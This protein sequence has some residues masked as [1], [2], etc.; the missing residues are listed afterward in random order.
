VAVKEIRKI[1]VNVAVENSVVYPS[2]KIKKWA[3][4]GRT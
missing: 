4:V 3:G 2:V 1:N